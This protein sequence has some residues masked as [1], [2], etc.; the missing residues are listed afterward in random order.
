MEPLGKPVVIFLILCYCFATAVSVDIVNV[1]EK[2]VSDNADKVNT[3]HEELEKSIEYLKKILHAPKNAKEKLKGK[4]EVVDEPENDEKKAL[5][6]PCQTAVC[7]PQAVCVSIG[8]TDY[9]CSCP[10]YSEPID[11][12]PLILYDEKG[13]NDACK[14][15]KKGKKYQNKKNYKGTLKGG[16]KLTKDSGERIHTPFTGV[17]DDLSENK[18]YNI[19]SMMAEHGKAPQHFGIRVSELEHLVP[20]GVKDEQKEKDM[21]II[22][23]VFD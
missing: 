14:K 7:H 19:E 17:V 6:D 11:K 1:N 10:S 3:G 22:A 18:N 2:G 16:L 15:K 4:V 20:D 21:S 12:N 13:K 5:A 9:K 8:H 23:D